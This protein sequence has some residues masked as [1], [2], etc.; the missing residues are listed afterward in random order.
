MG[1][2]DELDAE[3]SARCLECRLVDPAAV[4]LRKRV[5]KRLVLDAAFGLV[6][7]APADAM[8]L[9]RDV[10]ELEEERERALDCSLAFEPEC[11]NR[12]CERHSRSASARVAGESANPLLVVEQTLAF[13]LHE[14]TPE[15]VTEKPHIGAKSGVGRHAPSLASS[16]AWPAGLPPA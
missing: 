8:V 12:I 1:R 7:A 3:P 5:G 4:E 9:L 16:R 2:E 14:H 13:L 6:L 15:K 11:C 10:D